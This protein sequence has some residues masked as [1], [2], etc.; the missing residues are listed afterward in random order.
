VQ[1]GLNLPKRAHDPRSAAN[2]PE[3]EVAQ[4]KRELCEALEQQAATS[5]VL[6]VISNS[7]GD[8]EPIFAH[9]LV[10][11]VGICDATFGFTG[12]SES[13]DPEDVMALL[14]EYHAAAVAV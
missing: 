12:F 10:K 5:E 13:S 3:P 8:L 7:Q 11:A 2:N 14:R 4:L 9:M 1:K 6:Q